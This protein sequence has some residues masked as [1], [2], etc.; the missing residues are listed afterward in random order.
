MYG[1]VLS[2]CIEQVLL[3][4]NINFSLRLFQTF[5]FSKELYNFMSNIITSGDE[6]LFEFY[7]KRKSVSACLDCFLFFLYDSVLFF[8][9][10]I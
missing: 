6:E 2:D 8:I 4:T 3:K 10:G 5:F 1:K 7:I 9:G